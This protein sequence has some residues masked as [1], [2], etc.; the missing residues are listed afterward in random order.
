MLGQSEDVTRSI[1]GRPLATAQPRHQ[2]T[3]ALHFLTDAM[4]IEVGFIAKSACY[5]IYRKR[6]GAP[7]QPLEIQALLYGIAQAADW[8]EQTIEPKRT[9]KPTK[10]TRTAKGSGAVTDFVYKEREGKT[11]AI[12]RVLLAQLH[13]SGTQLVVFTPNWMP[14]LAALARSP[15]R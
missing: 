2:A 8:E 6:T 10:S 1:L 13:A 9:A 4:K 14:D 11:T 5:A 3:R 15:L 12:R 7:F